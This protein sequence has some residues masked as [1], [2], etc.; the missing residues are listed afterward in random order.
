MNP[1]HYYGLF[2]IF[3]ANS[4]RDVISLGMW[5]IIYKD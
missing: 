4:M 1:Q 3:L 2:D 5:D